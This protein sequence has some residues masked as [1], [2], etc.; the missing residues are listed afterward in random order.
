MPANQSNGLEMVQKCCK[1]TEDPPNY[2][3]QYLDEWC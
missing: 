1:E 3:R 2:V